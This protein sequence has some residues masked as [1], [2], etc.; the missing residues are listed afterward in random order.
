MPSYVYAAITENSSSAI[1]AP[2]T[3]S[4]LWVWH[5][6]GFFVVGDGSKYE[7]T[8]G[9]KA[10]K[11]VRIERVAPAVPIPD[12]ER[13][14]S[15]TTILTAM[16]RT[17]PSWSWKGPSL[18]HTKA[19]LAKLFVA[20]DGRIWAQV[21]APSERI[22]DAEIA[23][24]PRTARPGPVVPQFR[25]PQVWEVYSPTGTFLARVPF[26]PRAELMQADG[27]RVW[28]LDRDEDGLPAVLRL[29]IDPPIPR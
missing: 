20:R 15:E 17:D 18:P 12:E 1:G 2:H 9:R 4:S 28:V 19:P 23:S 10:A 26:A 21:P 7:I 24:R 22:P 27:N 6:D 11:P 16:H 5:P 29:R 14:A 3:P 13:R 8:L 25:S